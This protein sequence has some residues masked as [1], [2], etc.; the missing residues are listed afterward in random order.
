[1]KKIE[2]LALESSCLKRSLELYYGNMASLIKRGVDYALRSLHPSALPPRCSPARAQP[3][4]VWADGA[5][6]ELM[7]EF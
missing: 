4:F 3:L 2:R 7:F 6:F 5:K 1:M